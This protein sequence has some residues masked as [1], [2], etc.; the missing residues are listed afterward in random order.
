LWQ[1]EKNEDKKKTLVSFGE[2]KPYDEG[3]E[4]KGR[5]GKK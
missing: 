1:N 3:R 4:A 2:T 5:G